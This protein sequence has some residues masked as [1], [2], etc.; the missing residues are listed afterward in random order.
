VPPIVDPADLKLLDQAVAA[1]KAVGGLFAS[2]PWLAGCLLGA[3]GMLWLGRRM[4]QRRVAKAKAGMPI[5]K[6]VTQ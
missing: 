5:A 4:K 6:E 3:L 1:A 2:H